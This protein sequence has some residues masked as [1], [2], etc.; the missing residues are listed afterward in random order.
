MKQCHAFFASAAAFLWVPLAQALPIM[1][2]ANLSG[3]A[4]NPPNASPGTGTVTVVIDTDA[5]T[6]AINATWAGLV[7]TAPV[8]GTPGTSVAHIHCCTDAPGNVGVAVGPG[9]LPGFPVGTLSGTY[10]I[11]LDTEAASTYTTAFINNAVFGGGGTLAG[12]EA[13][14]LAGLEDGR[15]YF[16]I[17][18][19]QFPSGEIRG[20]LAIPE[21]AS[22][23]L[24]GL[25]LLGIG[26]ARRQRSA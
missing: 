25:G 24:L 23:A 3:S 7:N 12:A 20:F 21:P 1:F 10:Q 14:L 4:E 11:V 15:A 18:S 9:T 2:V 19:A 13:A 16:N 5:N 8:G 6:L 26:V 17:H 22:L